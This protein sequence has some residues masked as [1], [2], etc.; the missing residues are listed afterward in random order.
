MPSRVCCRVCQTELQPVFSPDTEY[1]F[2]N[3]LWVNFTGGYDMFVESLP[4]L[5]PP[6]VVLCHSCAHDLCDQVPWI[7]EL[8]DPEH[9]HQCE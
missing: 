3:A 2:D 9:S 8:L 1:Q 4:G 6:P 7:A 5:A